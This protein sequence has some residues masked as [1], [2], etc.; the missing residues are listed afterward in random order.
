MRHAV[1]QKFLKKK[2]TDS[3]ES[4]DEK[5]QLSLTEVHSA[6]SQLLQRAKKTEELVING[7]EKEVKSSE[8]LKRLFPAAQELINGLSS[9]DR[10]QLF[11]L[12]NKLDI[13]SIYLIL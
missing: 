7:R 11:K 10:A 9:S 3:S 5:K 4:S 8:K 6:L 1:I 13:E 12:S 2:G